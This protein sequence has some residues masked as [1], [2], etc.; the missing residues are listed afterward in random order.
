MNFVYNCLLVLYMS[1]PIKN[2]Y[3]YILI[4]TGKNCSPCIVS[5]DEFLATNKIK[6][7]LINLH[8]NKAE[9]TFTDETIKKFCKES[10]ASKRFSVKNKY[11]FGKYIFHAEDGGPFLIKYSESDTLI[12]NAAD[13]DKVT[14][15]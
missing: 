6:Y 4:I 7:K 1:L 10:T 12:F 3:S 2:H 8:Q 11:V 13:I 5:A 14:N 15:Y 9:K